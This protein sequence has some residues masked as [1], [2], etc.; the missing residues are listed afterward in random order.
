MGLLQNEKKL[1]RFDYDFA[2]DG[3][4]VGSIPLRAN[5]QSLEAGMVITDIYIYVEQ[6]LDDAG[7][8]ATVT[9]G[10]TDADGFFAD[11]AA[12]A[13]SDNA[14]IRVGEVAGALMYDDTNDHL[15][16]Y[17]VSSD[18]DLD[19]NI[20]TEALTQGKLQVYVEYFAP[21]SAS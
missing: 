21:E 13:A 4:A 14:V 20:G 15:L 9:V 11:I 18:T 17:R 19:L 1:A 5:V 8:T 10:N 16:C 7:G 6:A 12:L 3:G 2:V